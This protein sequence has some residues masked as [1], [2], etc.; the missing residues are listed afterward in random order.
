MTETLITLLLVFIAGYL[1]VGFSK[2]FVD[3]DNNERV[4]QIF[5]RL[6]RALIFRDRSSR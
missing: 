3:P 4:D 6:I 5:H 1:L 2:A